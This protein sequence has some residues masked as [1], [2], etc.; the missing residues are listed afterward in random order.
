MLSFERLCNKE[1][2]FS[3]LTGVRLDEFREIIR[4]VR[5]K[6]TEIQMRKKV[7][8]RNSKLKTLEDE[9]LLDTVVKLIYSKA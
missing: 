2:N 1:K 8:G 9:V 6:W 3:R 5:P 4:K 7:S